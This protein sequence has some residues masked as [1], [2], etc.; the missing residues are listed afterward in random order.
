MK[1]KIG[2]VI[3]ILQRDVIKCKL[4]NMV[5]TNH[6]KKQIGT[7]LNMKTF[8]CKLCNGFDYA[9]DVKASGSGRK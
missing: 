6:V 7:L 4:T 9:P 5:L 1:I 3:M 2:C 8:V